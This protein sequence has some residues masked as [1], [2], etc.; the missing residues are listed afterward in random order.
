MLKYVVGF[1]LDAMQAKERALFFF[2]EIDARKRVI[3]VESQIGAN[4][5]GEAAWFTTIWFEQADP[6]PEQIAEEENYFIGSTGISPTDPDWREKLVAQQLQAAADS[7]TETQVWED[8]TDRQD[9]T[10]AAIPS[11]EFEVHHVG[12]VEE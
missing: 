6:T 4:E 2:N 10:V 9:V 1:S 7:L 11:V 5:V 12:E 8:T 3:I